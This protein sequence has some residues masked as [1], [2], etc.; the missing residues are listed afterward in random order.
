MVDDIGNLMHCLMHFELAAV[1]RRDILKGKLCGLP[2]SKTSP[3][4][5]EQEKPGRKLWKLD[6]SGECMTRKRLAC[7]LTIGI[8]KN[9]DETDTNDNRKWKKGSETYTPSRAWIMQ[10]GD[11]LY[12]REKVFAY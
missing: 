6:E 7:K 12:R 1:A 5:N 4:P 11:F 2:C 10:Y 8:R 3:R 9:H